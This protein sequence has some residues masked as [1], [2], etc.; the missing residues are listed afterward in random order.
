VTRQLAADVSSAPEL[1]G[2]LLNALVEDP[3]LSVREGGAI[4]DGYDA[5]LDSI[6]EGSRTAR[7]W[8][9]KLE[10]LERRRT[11]IRTLKVGFNKVFGYYI[12]VSHAN[13]AKLPDGAQIVIL[14]GPNMAGKSTYLRQ[15]AVIVLLA[16]C[17]S[18]VPAEHAVIGLADRVFTRVGAHDDISAGMSTFMVEMTETAYILNHA[19]RSSLVILDE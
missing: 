1:A 4:R 9:A 16:Q 2:T 14:T 6:N 8:I 7:E 19:T 18:F 15:A 11:G 17:G 13:T 3:P 10:A 5:D 12:E